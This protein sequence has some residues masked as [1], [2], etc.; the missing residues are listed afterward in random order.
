MQLSENEMQLSE[1]SGSR[2]L[3]V[4]AWEFVILLFIFKCFLK[5]Y[6]WKIQLGMFAL[7]MFLFFFFCGTLN[8]FCC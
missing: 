8:E 1:T 6:Y 4:R 7:F 2:A 5:I 3:N